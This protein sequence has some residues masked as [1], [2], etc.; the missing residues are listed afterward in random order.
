MKRTKQCHYSFTDGPRD[1]HT[2]RSKS[3]R[4]I[5]YDIT[6]MWDLKCDTNGLSMKQ[7]DSQRES[8]LCGFQQGRGVGE[9]WTGNL[10]LADANHYIY[11]QLNHFAVH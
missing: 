8:R 5:S 9:E 11:V 7:K 4:Q 2:K 3:E 10:G 6:H 1:D